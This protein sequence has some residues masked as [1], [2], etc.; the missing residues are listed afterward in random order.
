MHML[1]RKY[2]YA[3]ALFFTALTVIACQQQHEN[4]LLSEDQ[5][6]SIMADIATAEAATSLMT[7]FE[8]DSTVK[9]YFQQVFLRNGTTQEKYEESLRTAVQ[10]LKKIER[11]SKKAEELLNEQKQR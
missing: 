4:A 9:V 5:L 7:G 6:A 10:D 2:Q 1:S 3:C 8:K 11:I